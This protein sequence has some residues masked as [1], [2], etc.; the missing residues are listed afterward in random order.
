[1]A[2]RDLVVMGASAGGV[3]ALRTVFG[4]LPK[5]LPA[6]LLVVLHVP[7]A[8]RSVL[9]AVLRRAGELPC[10]RAVH[11]APLVAG[12]A[13]VGVADH[14]LLVHE[15][16]LRVTRGPRVNGHR[17]AI[18]PLFHSAATWFAA[19]AVGVVLS[20]ALADGTAGL[21][22]LAR[23]GGAAIVQDPRDAAYPSMPASALA[24][25]PSAKIAAAR[26]IAAAICAALEA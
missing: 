17:P 26:E 10:V 23:A 25:V 12:V 6:A 21:V 9:D 16:R 5:D 4:H 18:D 15:G 11:G 13:H 19:R 22:A 20:G 3:E 24:A 14:H 1:M 2:K 7:A 8:G